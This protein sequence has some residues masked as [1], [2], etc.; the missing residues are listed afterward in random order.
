MGSGSLLVSQPRRN[1]QLWVQSLKRIRWRAMEEELFLRSSHEVTCSYGAAHSHAHLTPPHTHTRSHA[2]MH[3]DNKMTS[4]FYER[5]S[6]FKKNKPGL[7][8]YV[9]FLMGCRSCLITLPETEFIILQGLKILV[10]NRPT[11]T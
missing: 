10:R 8:L 9:V 7:N 6:T 2:R 1:S 3:A 5:S 4:R 11:V